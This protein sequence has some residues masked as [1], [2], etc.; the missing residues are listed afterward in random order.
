MNESLHIIA[1]KTARALASEIHG[2]LS[3]KASPYMATE[4]TEAAL[5]IIAIGQRLHDAAQGKSK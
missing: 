1:D 3:A 5:E 2:I 4:I